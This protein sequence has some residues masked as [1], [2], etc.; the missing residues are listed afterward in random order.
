MWKVE[1]H[2]ES[3]ASLYFSDGRAAHGGGGDVEAWR[4]CGGNVEALWPM[5]HENEGCHG[6]L[7]T[8]CIAVVS[9]PFPSWSLFTLSKWIR[10]QIAPVL[11]PLPSVYTAESG[12]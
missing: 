4:R 6:P 8:P 1:K 12:K 2:V 9:C 3:A 11:S 5:Y 7:S 10:A